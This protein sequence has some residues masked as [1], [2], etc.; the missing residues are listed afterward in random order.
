MAFTPSDYGQGMLL[1]GLTPGSSLT[2]F[3]A[4]ITKDNLP[5][6][7]LDTGSTS[8]LNG[9]GDWV[10]S[11]DSGG[12]NQLPCE[13]VTCVT[14]ATPASTEFEAW[15]RF[16]AYASGT[17]EVYAF[18]NRAGQSQPA[19][20]ATFGR[21]A[22]YVNSTTHQGGSDALTDV[23]GSATITNVGSAPLDSVSNFAARDIQGNTTRYLEVSG[24]AENY[25]GDFSAGAWINLNSTSP[26]FAQVIGIRSPAGSPWEW[27][28]RLLNADVGLLIGSGGVTGGTTLS[29]STDYKIDVTVSGTTATFY[30][31]GAFLSSSAIA[32]TRTNYSDTLKIGSYRT[33][34]TG[35][36]VDGSIGRAYAD[37]GVVKTADFIASEYD[38]QSDPAT[39]WTA[40]TPFVPS[41]GGATGTMLLR[42]RLLSNV[43][44]NRGFLQ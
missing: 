9:G 36:T 3:K 4:V 24:T 29:I 16:P 2:G 17:R 21:N 40:G 19:V 6:S 26:G 1:T 7:A 35:A 30:L 32:G 37:N 23:T 31:D 27:S 12:V 38:N 20:G 13:I 43:M 15:I 22:V 14:S 11:T 34:Q 25:T 5:T 28:L 33:G 39:F 8:C 44:L 18:W 42:N 10:F 41:G